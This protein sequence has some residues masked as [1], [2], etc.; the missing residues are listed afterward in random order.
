MTKEQFKA[1]PHLLAEGDVV[2]LGYS[3]STIRKF[4]DCGVLVKV[5]PAG[6]SAARYQKKQLAQLLHWEDVLEVAAFKS[7]PPF[8][9]VKA[10]HHWT[11]YSENTL[12]Q[13]G[14]ME[15]IQCSQPPGATARKFLKADVAKLIGFENFV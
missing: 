5:K 2:A 11:G 14:A 1:L 8:M 9:Q 10:V 4:V 7:E 13:I 12:A 15:G 3:P 6:T